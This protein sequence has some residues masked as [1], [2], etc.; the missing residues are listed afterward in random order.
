MQL[1][2]RVVRKVPRWRGRGVNWAFLALLG[3]LVVAASAI[4]LRVTRTPNDAD[5]SAATGSPVRGATAA[6]VSAPAFLWQPLA[7]QTYKVD[8]RLGYV[9]QQ[10]ASASDALSITGLWSIRV[11][12]VEASRVHL[13]TS[14]TDLQVH[15][16]GTR[17]TSVE[18]TL[19]GRL[20]YVDLGRDGSLYGVH[21]P[22]DMAR[23]D[24]QIL[25][26]L[27][28]VELVLPSGPG[29]WTVGST[30]SWTESSGAPRASVQGTLLDATTVRKVRQVGAAGS[31][32]NSGVQM[33]IVQSQFLAKIGGI[34]LEEFSGSERIEITSGAEL[35]STMK[36]SVSIVLVDGAIPSVLLRTTKSDRERD[37][38]VTYANAKALR[39]GSSAWE[40][41]ERLQL[42]ER[43]RDVPAS[44]MVNKMRSVVA[45]ASRHVETVQAIHELRDW[46]QADETHAAELSKMLLGGGFSPAE[47][48][49]MVNALELAS[50]TP[51]AQAALTDIFSN[52]EADDV[53]RE[54]AFV[55]AADVQGPVTEELRD[56]FVSSALGT[57]DGELGDTPLLN[58]G[59]LAKSDPA[60]AEALEQNFGSYLEPEGDV[61]PARLSTVIDAF[62]NAG[63]AGEA[64]ADRVLEL[65]QTHP[66]PVVRTSAIDYL[67]RLDGTSSDVLQAA[68]NDPAA[69]VQRVAVDALF[70]EGRN[71]DT[72]A[73]L[74]LE[75]AVRPDA[76]DGI[77][78]RVVRAIA[79]HTDP[80]RYREQ[81]GAIAELSSDQS[82]GEAVDAALKGN[83]P[84]ET[85]EQGA[86][87]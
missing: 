16:G 24:A 81:L 87:L 29:P 37:L 4:V 55:A 61:S 33:S 3:C 73:A 43:Y 78:L 59:V 19:E 30:W 75:L 46:I 22:K 7:V 28:S 68:L 65:L 77:R 66:A 6:Q 52:L 51:E 42:R 2:A 36:T 72:A 26:Q 11:L 83:S 79:E 9:G 18:R 57:P 85:S 13:A 76:T 25:E 50:A 1:R 80:T 23:A 35:V 8:W 63:A 56:A 44:S 54:Q 40:E 15:R 82:V 70:H 32:H 21:V 60:S 20:A 5:L 69:S 31:D 41:D 71:V 34:W 27:N 45:G 62:A 10:S 39:P 58:L 86:A 47:S 84:I 48:A 64:Q 14:F 12:D 67:A 49:R 38:L 53:L 74:T 17:V